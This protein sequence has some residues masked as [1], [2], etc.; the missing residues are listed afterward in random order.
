MSTLALLPLAAC[1]ACGLLGLAAWRPAY[2]CGALAFAIP[3]TAGLARGAVIPVL[4]VNEALLAVVAAGF[5]IH[6]LIQRRPLPGRAQSWTFI[7]LDIIIFTFC[8]ANVLIPWGVILLSRDQAG[9]DDWLVVIAP[10]QYLLVYVLY[11]RIELTGA[12]L[13]LLFN[14]LMLASVVVAAV[15]VAEVFDVGGARQLVQSY[16]P[17]APLPPGDRVYRP[18][19]L[20][21]HYSAVGAFGLLNFLLAFALA[22]TRHPG[23]SGWWLALVMGANL[24]ALIA[25]QTYAPAI[26]LPLGALAVVLVARRLP[27]RQLAAGPPVVAAAALA[28]WPTISGRLAAQSGGAVGFG[29]PETLQTR[30][31]YWQGFF[32][33]ALVRHGPWLGTGT[34]IPA[35][36]PRPLVDFVDNGYLWAM[37]RAGIPG[38]AVLIGL[39]GGVAVTAWRGRTSTDGRLRTVGAVCLGA[40]GSLTLLD[41]TS[42][43]LSFTGVSQEF[44][45]LVGL[46]AG[47]VMAGTHRTDHV[48][49]V[50]P[51]GPCRPGLWARLVAAVRRLAPERVLLRGSIGVFLGFGLARALGFG[52]QVAAARILLP[53]GYGRLIYALAAANVATVLLSTGPL[54]LSRFLSRSGDNRADQEAYYTNW[55]AVVGV[56]LGA[57]AVVTA[58]IASP[59]GL[60]GW[61]LAGL[62]ANLLGVA[63]LETYREVQR[64]LGRYAL[65]SVFYVLANLLQLAAVIAAAGLGWRSPA[66]FLIIYGLSP[67]GALAL[68]APVSGGLRLNGEALRWGRMLGIAGFIRPVLLQA[69]FWNVWFNV[70]LLMLQHLRTAA[71]TGTYAAAKTI[72]NGFTLIPMAIAFVFAPR[73]AQLTEKQVRG[74]LARVLVFTTVA[75]VPVATGLMLVA[76]PLTRGLFGDGYEAA[77]VPLALLLAAMVPYG[78]KTVLG[79]LWLG[80]GHPVVETVSSAVAMIVTAGGGLWLIPLRG[81]VGAAVAFGAGAVAMLLVDGAVGI[82]AFSARSPRL[83]HIRERHIIDDEPPTK[84]P[85]RHGGAGVRQ[86]T[87]MVAEELTAAPDEAGKGLETTTR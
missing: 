9:L 70:D 85:T 55:L 72:A 32:V 7:G 4:R 11:S 41:T 3:I 86:L 36:V 44:W 58:A 79:G 8:A 60:G 29:I 62:L 27:W 66:L 46:L 30:I 52:F 82:W 81:P 31:D 6:L 75:T 13:R 76:G 19:S 63:A 61:M 59:I 15:A 65:Q 64:G 23:F 43:Y 39:I 45:M 71:E 22:A 35:E 78:L 21:G 69:V 40:V 33:P 84:S 20:L 17:T 1:A 50:R 54:G 2:A 25:S 18:A 53:D 80:L 74:H 24:I 83:G 48:I 10:I 56:L 37:F 14:P 42:E 38:L 67:V 28:F 87:L 26:A 49:E 5:L 77:T 16:Y 68:M 57:S 12:G 73:V 34:L 51:E 47:V